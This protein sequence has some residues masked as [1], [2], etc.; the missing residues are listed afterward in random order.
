M[1]DDKPQNPPTPDPPKKLCA[2]CAWRA[3]C[4]KRFSVSN[5]AEGEVRCLDHAYDIAMLK[6]SREE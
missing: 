4:N 2:N 3:N 5:T 6:K 1:T